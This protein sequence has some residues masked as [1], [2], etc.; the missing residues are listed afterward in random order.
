[1]DKNTYSKFQGHNGNWYVKQNN[2]IIGGF[3]DES[4]C[5][6]FLKAM[7]ILKISAEDGCKKCANNILSQSAGL[8]CINNCMNGSKFTP[9][10]EIDNSPL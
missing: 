1:M 10:N 9:K 4:F 3:V 2:K 5:D 7:T 6:V 8:W